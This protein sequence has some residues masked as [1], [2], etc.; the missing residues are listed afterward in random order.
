[1]GEHSGYYFSQSGVRFHL[2]YD[3]NLFMV[4]KMKLRPKFIGQGGY[5]GPVR[6]ILEP[7]F[8]QRL[9]WAVVWATLVIYLLGIHFLAVSDGLNR[10]SAYLDKKELQQKIDSGKVGPAKKAGKKNK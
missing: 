10:Y 1:M 8:K 5:L 2:P 9:V 6:V 3:R 7:T 4:D